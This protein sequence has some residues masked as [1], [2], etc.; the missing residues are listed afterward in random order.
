MK[1]VITVC[2]RGRPDGLRACL[3]SLR[4]L[5][6]EPGVTL[7][8]VV[9]ENEPAP[10]QPHLH[11][12]DAALPIHYVHEPRLGIPVARNR[13]AEAA[14]ARGADWIGFIDDDE[15][16]RP[17]WLS[18]M[19]AAIRRGDADVI[20]GG[21]MPDYGADAPDWLGRPHPVDRPEGAL[22]PEAPTN[23]T[24]AAR[25]IFEDLALRFDERIGFGGG[26][27]VDFFRRATRAGAVIRWTTRAVVEERWP[28]VRMTMEWHRRRSFTDAE[29]VA[30]RDLALDGL[31][32][33]PGILFGALRKGVSGGALLLLAVLARPCAARRSRR[34]RFRGGKKL[35]EATGRM[36]GLLG[37]RSERYRVVDG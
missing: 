14:L 28:P 27:D 8:A 29:A 35:A 25:R 16:V 21:V 7:E 12:P 4:A 34:W 9:V 6:P 33:T 23:N 24:L 31:R 5:P 32:A 13:A 18:A 17:D 30:R 37:R 20:V 22:M 3:E 2:T 1:V 10:A 19:T 36:A 15:T 11:A 26:S